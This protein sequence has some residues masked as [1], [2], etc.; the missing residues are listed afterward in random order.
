MITNTRQQ[1]EIISARWRERL[2]RAFFGDVKHKR[3]ACSMVKI[4]IVNQL[5]LLI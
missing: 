2:A 5:N 4:L 3:L 1:R